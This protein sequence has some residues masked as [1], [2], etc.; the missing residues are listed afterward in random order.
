M[1][2]SAAVGILAIVGLATARQPSAT[3]SVPRAASQSNAA[4][5][6]EAPARRGLFRRQMAA[7]SD[8]A[9][10]DKTAFSAG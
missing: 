5:A 2:R 1:S 8:S 9:F 3:P 4:A 6:L 7:C 10:V